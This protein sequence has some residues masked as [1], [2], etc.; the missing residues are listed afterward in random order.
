MDVHHVP[1]AD[2]FAHLADG[3]EERQRLDV[4]DRA[5]YLDDDHVRAAVAGET[6]DPFLDLV[7]DVGDDLDG[8]AQIVAAALFADDGLVDAAGRDVGE[9][10]EVLVDEPLVVPQIQVRLGAV[11]GDED[12]T[13]LV[14]R[15][16]P[17]VDVDVRIELQDGDGKATGLEEPADAGGGDSLSQ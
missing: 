16:R 17:G 4:S 1:P 11:V 13:V 5:A 14:G 12:F 10:R 2:V 9:L 8:A 15:H 3:L 7:R 6:L